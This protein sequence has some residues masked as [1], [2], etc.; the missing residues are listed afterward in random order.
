MADFGILAAHWLDN[1]DY[2][3]TLTGKIMC[4]Y[5][6]WFNT[7]T[8]GA[9]LNWTHWGGNPFE[10]GNCS[11]DM[12]PD[13]SEYDADEKFWT[14]FQYSDGNPA[15]VFSSYNEKTV[16]RHFS[17]MAEYGIDG[18][19]LQRFATETNP[20][21]TGQK[22]R[23]QVMLHCRKGG[24]QYK[25][26]WAMMYDISGLGEGGTQRVIDDWKHLVDTYGV[27]KD[28]ED[29]AYLH[30]NGKPVVAIWGIGFKDRSYTLDEC[31]NMVN[32]FKD[33]PVYGGLTVMLG[34]PSYWR[35]LTKDCV[36]DPKV[37]EIV[38]AADIIS[39]WA[40]GRFGSKY[41]NELDGYS[42][43]VWV[44]DVAWCSSRNIDYLPV[45]FPGFSWQNLKSE[46]WDHIPRRG[47][48]FLWRQYYKAI[49]D[50]GVSMVYQAMFDEV[51]EATAIFKCSNNPPVGTS[52]FLPTGNAS[53][54]P[55]DI[56]DAD[57]PSDH[58]LWLVGEAGRMLR[59]EIAPTANMPLR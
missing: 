9:N 29:K 55:Y 3:Q 4:G 41:D 16:L 22:H 21:S 26:A 43:N 12:W 51:D 13:M 34:I 47:G 8:D 49:K 28:S 45:V 38:L 5:Q 58:Y 40:V 59:G 57:L 32:F 44:K 17:W 11:I 1:N 23:D 50:A 46:K 30:H 14:P 42:A 27:G 20:G 31:L 10:P 19:F 35:T 56:S 6:G 37:H 48:R 15:Y 52:P 39:P 33:D 36:N 18:V 54:P 2:S 25:R 7:P 24:E 53:Y